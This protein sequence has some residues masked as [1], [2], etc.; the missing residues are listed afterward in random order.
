MFWLGWSR[1]IIE[2]KVRKQRERKRKNK[3]VRVRKGKVLKMVWEEW[4]KGETKDENMSKQVCKKKS[5][6]G[7]EG[8]KIKHF[9]HMIYKKRHMHP[10]RIT[11]FSCWQSTTI[12]HLKSVILFN[13]LKSRYRDE[14]CWNIVSTFSYSHR[15]RDQCQ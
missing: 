6:K 11:H 4:K 15:A 3:C 13:L 7:K 1:I 2:K 12:Q 8:K 14:R 10:I 5:S 9:L